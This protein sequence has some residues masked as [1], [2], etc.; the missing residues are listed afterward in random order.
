MSKGCILWLR[1]ICK[2]IFLV[3]QIIIG[4]TC[5]KVCPCPAK[6]CILCPVQGRHYDLHITPSGFF[7]AVFSSNYV[8]KYSGR[9][10][11]RTSKAGVRL[12]NCLEHI[13]WFKLVAYLPRYLIDFWCVLFVYFHNNTLSYFISHSLCDASRI[14]KKSRRLKINNNESLQY[15]LIKAK[16]HRLTH[17][18]TS[19]EQ[20]YFRIWNSSWLPWQ[21]VS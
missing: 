16:Y 21:R 9:L 15:I 12:T 7:K 3:R 13:L 17:H 14:I 6:L 5:I 10:S 19:D 20:Q 11:K 2:W 4:I 1:I 8:C 18:C